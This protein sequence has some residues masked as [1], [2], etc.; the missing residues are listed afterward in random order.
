MGDCRTFEAMA[1]LTGLESDMDFWFQ[2]LICLIRWE[3]IMLP[4]STT[5]DKVTLVTRFSLSSWTV[6]SRTASLIKPFL[7]NS[8][9]R[10]F[11]R[12]EETYRK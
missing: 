6:P 10:V 2:P 8:F 12:R 1:W 11:V 3:Q 7:S 5:V 9:C 4:A